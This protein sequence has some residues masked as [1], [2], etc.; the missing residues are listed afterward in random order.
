VSAGPAD[1]APG[2][3]RLYR[4]DN[5]ANPRRIVDEPGSYESDLVGRFFT[6]DPAM[7][8]KFAKNTNPQFHPRETWR[9]GVVDPE[10]RFID[11]PID[12]AES[13]RSQRYGGGLRHEFLLPRELLENTQ[14]GR[15]PSAL[16][17]FPFGGASGGAEFGFVTPQTTP[18]GKVRGEITTVDSTIDKLPDEFAEAIANTPG[19]KVL[20]EGIKVDTV[21]YQKPEQAGSTAVRGGVFFLPEKKSRFRHDYSENPLYGGPQRIEGEATYRKPLIVNA[22]SGGKVPERAYDALYHNGAYANMRNIAFEWTDAS[23]RGEMSVSELTANV[24]ALLDRYGVDTALAIPIVKHSTEGNQLAYAL[25]EAIV[26]TAVRDAG[27]D[28]LLGYSKAKG[29]MRLSEVF[30]VQ[31]DTFP[32]PDVQGFP[33]RPER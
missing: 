18:G 29:V 30:D 1:A 22:P 32:V 12:V 3:V 8:E 19:A 6:D 15:L 27:Y 23:I 4:G 20:D 21:R 17:E 31:A 10:V 9:Q 7:A 24:T 11:V 2:Y 33:L 5:I 13:I 25:Q 26:A 28:A 16:P 14:V